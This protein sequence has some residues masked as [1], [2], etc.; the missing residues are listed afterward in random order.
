MLYGYDFQ[1]VRLFDE[2]EKSN[3]LTCIQSDILNLTQRGQSQEGRENSIREKISKNDDSIQIHSCHSPMRE[4]QVLHDN[5][6]SMFE[7]DNGLKPAD[8][9][10]MTPDINLYSP[11]ILAVFDR[12]PGDPMNIPFGI[13]D[14][15]LM[16][17]GLVIQTFLKILGLPKAR[18]GAQ[19]VFSILESSAV[20]EKFDLTQKDLE[21][22]NSSRKR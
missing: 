16:D 12:P 9:V 21:Q 2:P 3:M 8:I 15:S 19:Q 17:E 7:K 4:V 1:E 18:L 13:A 6:L 22:L 14:Q 5:L 20:H 11:Y 10:V